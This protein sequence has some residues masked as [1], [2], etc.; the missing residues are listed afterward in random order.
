MADK[1]LNVS[2]PDP[3]ADVVVELGEDVNAP[4][5]S[6]PAIV[7]E[8]E[9]T[10]ATPQEPVKKPV[11]RVRLKE[12]GEEAS[13]SKPSQAAEE[14]AAALSASL[15]AAE[16][17]ARNAE[18]TANAERNARAEAERRAAAAQADAN[19][20]KEQVL[21]RE[22]S[23]VTSGI[24]SAQSELD[25]LQADLTR[26]YEAGEFAKV[27]EVQVKIGKATAKLDRLS[28]AKLSIESGVAQR[29]AAT[30]T[31]GRVEPQPQAQPSLFERYVSQYA[32]VAQTWLRSHPECTPA[33]VGGNAA[34][35][36]KML[37]GHYEAVASG[38][39]E[40]S[41]D[42]FAAIEAR[43]N[44][45]PTV[46]TSPLSAAAEPRPAA[47]RT[48]PKPSAPPSREPPTANNIPRNVRQVTLTKEQQEAARMSFP[49][50]D[51]K[52]AYTQYALNLIELTAEGKMG[53]TTH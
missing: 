12:P 44:S 6:D 42:Y 8:A 25:G 47:P 15:K 37:A 1:D 43:L 29:A 33:E 32:P 31:S 45:E 34:A 53:R 49:Q 27:S 9:G 16:D 19:A 23:I 39:K 51:P 35:H 13:P 26:L 18:A 7:A 17:R 36:A 24:D 5:L 46:T 10:G 50:L 30:S 22:L 14:A 2:V 40:G 20:A 48:P 41:S 21:N 3:D 52:A 38:L 4:N 28:E 11:P